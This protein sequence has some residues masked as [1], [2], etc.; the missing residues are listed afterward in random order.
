MRLSAVAVLLATMLTTHAAAQ[1]W[2]ATPHGEQAIFP[3]GYAPFPHVSRAKGH[4]YRDKVFTYADSYADPSVALFLP[5]GFRAG[6]C[7]DL[8]FYWHGWSN[9]VTTAMESFALREMVVASGRN[10][11]LVFPEGPRNASDSGAGKME[12]EGGLA[13]LAD[14]VVGT[15]RREQRIPESATLG[16]VVLSGHSGAYRAMARCLRHGGLDDH[17]SEVYLLDASYGDLEDF[18]AW[19]TRKPEG[20][21]V[22]VYTEHLRERNEQMMATLTA[23]G[24]EHLATTHEAVTNEELAA[25]RRAFVYTTTLDHNQAVSRLE[26]F[27]ATSSLAPIPA[28]PTAA[29]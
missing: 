10:V 28:A 5:K 17:I 12:D 27:L 25:A 22:S 13:R 24:I 14:E 29:E 6:E 19:M 21:L 20:R 8:L 15:L 9:T 11:V 3:M 16:R 4:Q 2:T 26:S 1:N 23:A 7:V 18:T